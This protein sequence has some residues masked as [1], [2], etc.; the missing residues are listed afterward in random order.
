MFIFNLSLQQ[1]VFPNQPKIAKVTP[2]FKSG[3]KELAN[4]YR[5][6]SVLPCFSKLFE[7]IIHFR[8]Y[9]LPNLFAQTRSLF[10]SKEHALRTRFTYLKILRPT[11]RHRDK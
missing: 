1:G 2:I 10:G 3:S 7:R 5:P 6:I 4:N 9:P 11:A 8:L